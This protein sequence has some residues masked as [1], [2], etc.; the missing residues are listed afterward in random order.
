MIEFTLSK[1]NLLI[2]VLAVTAIV[3]F[4][5]NTV[6]SNLRTRQAYE[7]VYKIGQ[8]IKTG[9]DNPS[10]CSIKY[11]EIPRRIKINY[12]ITNSY[13]INY[14][15]NIS[16][17]EIS[18]DSDIKKIVLS[19]LDGQ[20]KN[21][22]AAYDLDINGEVVFYD[23]TF[24]SGKYKYESL[25]DQFL[26]LNPEK[27]DSIDQTIVIAK[28]I[29]DGRQTIHIFA[30]G[31]KNNIPGCSNF[32]SEINGSSNNGDLITYLKTEEN[33]D[34]ICLSNPIA[35]EYTPGGATQNLIDACN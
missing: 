30:C 23:W 1:L 28:K 33:I 7:L 25:S 18:S 34:C 26:D 21:I 35:R 27:K 31:K 12:G 29:K 9:V 17:H 11:V 5:M 32:Y 8:E 15:L 13:N 2:F 14:L 22:F 10:Y 6:N 19:I 3:V 24:D 16:A 20:K 4:F